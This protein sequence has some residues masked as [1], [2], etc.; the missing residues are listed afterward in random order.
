[1]DLEKLQQETENLQQVDVTKLSPEQLQQ[2]VDKLSNIL[3]QSEQSLLQ[4]SL[5]EIKEIENESND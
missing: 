3:E 4:T 5:N 2:L 1:M